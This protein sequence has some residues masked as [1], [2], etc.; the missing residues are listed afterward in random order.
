MS[1][2]RLRSAGFSLIELMVTIAIIAIMMAL[3]IPSIG[4]SVTTARERALEQ[5]LIQDFTWARGAAGTPDAGSLISGQ[6]GQPTLYFKVFANGTW[7]T[8]LTVPASP[9]TYVT[10]NVH[11]MAAPL[12]VTM[13]CVGSNG[14]TLPATFQFTPQGTLVG[15]TGTI[16]CTGGSGQVFPMNFIYSGSVFRTYGSTS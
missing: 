2:H 11:S 15:P 12:P 10:E 4:T 5:K 16:T 9:S 6:S 14:L 13:S 3:A 1:P 8:Y 7:T